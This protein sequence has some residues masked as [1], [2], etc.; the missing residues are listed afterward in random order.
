MK[1]LFFIFLVCLSSGG[2]GAKVVFS[3]LNV[4]TDTRLLFQADSANQGAPGQGA[5]FVCRLTDLNLKQITAFPEKIDLIEQGKTLQIRNLFGTMRI[6]V[7]GGLPQSIMGCSSFVKGGM[8]RE[9]RVEDIATSRDG[10][11]IL[12]VEAVTTAYGNL[13]LLDAASG[14]KTIV[15]YNIDRP[16]SDFPACWSP[17]SQVFVYTRGGRLYYYTVAE[18][19]AVLS[20]ERYRLIGDG[21]INSVS[22]GT[23]GD[24]FY[25]RGSILY[26]VRN[27]ELFTRSAYTDFLEIGMVAGMV[28]F[29]FDPNFDR[30]WIA[31]DSRS[32][33]LSKGG[34]NVFLY[35][36]GS[37]D[38]KADYGASMPYLMVPRSCFNLKVLWSPSGVITVIASVFQKNGGD[39][40]TY[41]LNTG[42]GREN[43]F[44]LLPAPENSQAALSPDGTKVLFWGKKGVVLY[45]YIDWSILQTISNRPAFSCIW[46]G[47]DAFIIGDGVRIEGVRI[48]G[49]RDA[50]SSRTL[51]CL[52][53]AEEF[54]FEEQ[55]GR[56]LARSDGTW[57]V[58]N[59]AVPWSEIS[60]PALR[61]ASLV[62]GRYHVYLET[63]ESGPYENLPMIRSIASPVG[64]P[65]VPTGEF[66]VAAKPGE[67][68]RGSSD[69]LGT[70]ITN[71]CRTG[72]QEVALCFDLYDDVTGLFEVLDA[73]NR[74]NLKVTFFLNGEFIRRYPAA[75]MVIADAGHETASMFFLPINLSDYHSGGDFIARGLTRTRDEFYR[76]SGSELSP[77]WHPPYYAVS[78]QIISIA[79]G[80]GYKTVGRDVDP[81]DWVSRDDAKRSGIFQYSASEMV[82]R[83]MTSKQPGSI[84]PIRLGLLPGGRNDYLFSRINVLLDAL[85]TSGYSVVPVST[86]IEH[87][88]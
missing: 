22:W 45:D 61:A 51:L 56:I 9:G 32:M 66:R 1:K 65:L 62:S 20:D 73:L 44:V 14:T 72:P 28:P 35:P 63:L 47:S 68:P 70:L 8:L 7:S 31:P 52:A 80:V 36:L 24:F 71:G 86:I 34:R 46:T 74:F 58:T 13:V 18:A 57:F 54:G 85:V 3:G 64:M 48:S 37:E 42:M 88:R 83:I 23:G 50:S 33:L 40:M 30:F 59:G 77:L 81:L 41:R 26:R 38:Y 11:W 21:A 49:Q 29:E 69:G 55:T 60:N 15:A 43:G 19:S 12:M 87:A 16:D 27:T 76:T 2:L 78:S 75:A 6:P 67:P 53:V 39:V 25:L 84:I 4:S 79:S 82:D 17:D 5:L 10:K